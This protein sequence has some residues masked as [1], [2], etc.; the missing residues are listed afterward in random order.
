[1]QNQ[2]IDLKNTI[3]MLTYNLLIIEKEFKSEIMD[4]E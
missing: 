2:N 4:K 1:M 3:V